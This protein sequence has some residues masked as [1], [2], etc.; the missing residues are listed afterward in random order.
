MKLY[1]TLF[2]LSFAF[3]AAGCAKPNIDGRLNTSYANVTGIVKTEPAAPGGLV[4]VN[5]DALAN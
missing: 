3:L 5:F 1:R 2:G 4:F